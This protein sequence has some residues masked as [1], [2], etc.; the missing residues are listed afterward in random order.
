M[1]WQRIIELGRI[2]DEEYGLLV[3]IAVAEF[4]GDVPSAWRLDYDWIVGSQTGKSLVYLT[5]NMVSRARVLD[6]VAA[7]VARRFER[8]LEQMEERLGGLS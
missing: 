1:N 7:D 4:P 5:D 8:E 2:L 3:G 6:A